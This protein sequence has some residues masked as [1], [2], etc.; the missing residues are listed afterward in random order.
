MLIAKEPRYNI[1]MK[2]LT[3]IEIICKLKDLAHPCNEFEPIT[4]ADAALFNVAACRIREL[5][6]EL[7][8]WKSAADNGSGC[9]NPEGL[10]GFINCCNC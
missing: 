9:D 4:R 5:E 3:N 2:E 8:A 10:A 6:D 1:G 7:K